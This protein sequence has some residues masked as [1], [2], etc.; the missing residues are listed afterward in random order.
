MTGATA[1]FSFYAHSSFCSFAGSFSC[2]SL[3]CVRLFLT[4]WTTACQAS[5]SFTISW[6]LLKFTSI[7]WVILSNHLNFC[8]PLLLLSLI[9]PR[10]RVYSSESA[11]CIKWPKFWSFSLSISPSNEY[12]GLISF[13][14]DWF[15]L[16]ASMRLSRAFSSTTIWKHQ[17]FGAEPSSWCNSHMR[18]LL[19]EEP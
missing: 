5:L 10:I 17:F 13:R 3:S 18:T 15:D 19:M 4:Q 6:S 2:C 12:S 7:Q 14:I 16:L 8:C 1:N 9:F 11:L